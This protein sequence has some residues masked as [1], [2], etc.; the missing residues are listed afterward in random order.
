M[1]SNGATYGVGF[2]DDGTPM[3]VYIA[4]DP[5]V[6]MLGDHGGELML[7]LAEDQMTYLRDGEA[8]MSGTVVM[9]NERE[10]TVTMGED[11]WS[12]TFIMPMATVALG[13]SEN[14]LSR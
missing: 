4:P 6:V 13:G 3:A 8:F 1:A 5:T 2:G 11:G 14:T 12:A 10:Y 7:T 9:A